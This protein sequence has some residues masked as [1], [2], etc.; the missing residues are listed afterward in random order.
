[1]VFYSKKCRENYMGEYFLNIQAN[2]DQNIYIMQR[3]E[4]MSVFLAL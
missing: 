1:M 2:H 4:G 3:K